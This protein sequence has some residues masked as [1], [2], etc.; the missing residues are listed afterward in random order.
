MVTHNVFYAA[1]A[2]VNGAKIGNI[3][4]VSDGAAEIELTNISEQEY[5][6]LVD[7][8]NDGAGT[9]NLKQY[10]TEYDFIKYLIK[11]KLK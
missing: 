1:L 3:T 4:I 10:I 7:E 6:K 8:Y 9:K 2:K 11:K 5:N